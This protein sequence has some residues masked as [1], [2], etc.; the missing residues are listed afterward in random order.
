LRFA[1]ETVCHLSQRRDMFLSG[2]AW[3]YVIHG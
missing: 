1:T 2:W 3:R